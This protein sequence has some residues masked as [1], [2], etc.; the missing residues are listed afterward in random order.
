MACLK[1]QELD[2]LEKMMLDLGWDVLL[3]YKGIDRKDVIL[4]R[5]S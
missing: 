3:S 4:F 1:F 2:P 5:S